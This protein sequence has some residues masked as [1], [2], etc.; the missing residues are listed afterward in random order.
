MFRYPKLKQEEINLLKSILDTDSSYK[1]NKMGIGLIINYKYLT[2]KNQRS[3]KNSF[4]KQASPLKAELLAIAKA[5]D[6]CP[7]NSTITINTDS[8]QSILKL[9]SLTI[10]NS[11]QLKKL[12]KL[13]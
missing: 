5:L 8:Q 4:T 9:T 10:Q 2:L 11:K 6:I 12:G 7:K 1:N 3:L 13:S